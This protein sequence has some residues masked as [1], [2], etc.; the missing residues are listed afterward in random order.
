MARDVEKFMKNA[1][2]QHGKMK[3]KGFSRKNFRKK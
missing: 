3:S 2:M 1:T